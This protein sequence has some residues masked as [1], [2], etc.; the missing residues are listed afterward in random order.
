[1][2]N[3]EIETDK[4]DLTDSKYRAILQ[5]MQTT[6]RIDDQIYRD[7]K[8]QAARLGITLTQFIEG[9]LQERI[10]QSVNGGLAQGD[11]VAERNQIMEQLL[12]ATAHFR[13][14]QRPTR[15]EMNER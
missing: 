4:K 9:A 15:E 6:L 14:G 2:R 5:T 12:L 3:L 13:A 1:L 10:K 7:A 11:A 8:A